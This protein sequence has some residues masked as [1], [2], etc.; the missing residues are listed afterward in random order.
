LRR[1]RLGITTNAAAEIEIKGNPAA[2]L[3]KCIGISL[4]YVQNVDERQLT[5]SVNNCLNAVLIRFRDIG[6]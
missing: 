4:P 2:V 3:P 1:K 5:Y 6:E